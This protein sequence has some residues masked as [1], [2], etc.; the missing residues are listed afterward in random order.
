MERFYLS[1]EKLSCID[2]E[3]EKRIAETKEGIRSIIRSYAE[4]IQAK[5]VDFSPEMLQY[6]DKAKKWHEERFRSL[7]V[8]GV[9]WGEHIFK[10]PEFVTESNGHAS[11]GAGVITVG[12]LSKERLAPIP[13]EQ[14]EATE[15]FLPIRVDDEQILGGMSK[16]TAAEKLREYLEALYISHE[17][18]HDAAPVSVFVRT[19]KD[20]ETGE[21]YHAT[22]GNPFDRKGVHYARRT[23]PEDG[24]PALEEG[25]A[26]TAQGEAASLAGRQFP[27]GAALYNRLL[28]FVVTKD[29]RL[30]DVPRSFLS[31]KNFDGEV[32]RYGPIQYMNGYALTA[33]LVRKIPNFFGLVED[34]RIN[35]RT[36]PLVRVVE[37]KFGR[38]SY[39]RIVTCPEGKAVDLLRELR[40]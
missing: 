1:K 6:I 11:S 16:E 25:L 23:R 30:Q 38:G 34:A 3:E 26:M 40:T 5:S 39:K 13:D 9:E 35:G 18:Y 12:D 21:K 20:R 28:D 33:Y 17:L 36:L 32:V 15:D 27:E 8:G 31:I 37:K 7:G 24:P 29:P 2:K 19:V 10:I 14:I 22:A 4:S